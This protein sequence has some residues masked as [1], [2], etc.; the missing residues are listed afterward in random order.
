MTARSREGRGDPRNGE[1]GGVSRRRVTSYDVAL[2]AGVTQ[3]TVSR[4]MRG[5][6]VAEATRLRVVAAAERLGYVPSNL[7]R[8]LATRQT[9][10]GASPSPI[11]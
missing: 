5:D 6:K 4:A 11:C 9:N 7:G 10:R 1:D 2:L 3:P 8:S